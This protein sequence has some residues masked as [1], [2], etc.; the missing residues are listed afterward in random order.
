MCFY[1]FQ[2]FSLV[3]YSVKVKVKIKVRVFPIIA[4]TTLVLHSNPQ[5]A[6]LIPQVKFTCYTPRR[7]A[8]QILTLIQ[9]LIP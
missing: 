3:L 7:W 6:P 9:I 4:D 8:I 1:L 5:Y 2:K